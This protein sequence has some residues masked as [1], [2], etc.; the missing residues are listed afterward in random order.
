MLD[1]GIGSLAGSQQP[2][3]RGLRSEARATLIYLAGIT[4]DVN[5]GGEL[6]VTN[7][8]R[9]RE[10]EQRLDDDDPGAVDGSPLHAA[11]WSFDIA[12]DYESGDQAQ[13][14]QFALDRLR[15]LALIDYTVEPEVIHV[16]ASD[17]VGPL[18]SGGS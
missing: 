14:F 3:Y 1:P 16:T 13:A 2:L 5:G 18:L 9:D 17:Q 8:V 7:A 11:G 15:A 10:Y 12:R 4:R 6:T